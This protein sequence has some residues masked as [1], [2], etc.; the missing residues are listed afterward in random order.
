MMGSKEIY[1]A[2][3]FMTANLN[4][5]DA[6][7]R[8]IRQQQEGKGRTSGGQVGPK[9]LRWHRLRTL[10][11]SHAVDVL[12][13][14]EHHYK[15]EQGESKQQAM[16][17]LEKGMERFKWV[18]WESAATLADAPHSGLVTFW[19]KDKF[20]NVAVIELEQRVLVTILQD[21]DGVL[22]TVVNAH[23]HND[24]RQRRL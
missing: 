12:A 7:E 23:F 9:V 1:R 17:R 21:E 14:H 3:T 18:Q 5:W 10:L 11:K 22:W 2:Q 8:E 13:V 20:I 19:R 15:Q 16:E 24:A 4:G 6:E